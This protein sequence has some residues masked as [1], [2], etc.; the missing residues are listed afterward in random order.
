MKTI[1]VMIAGIAFC[2]FS[3]SASAQQTW[4]P[5]KNSTVDSINAKYADKILPPRPATTIEQIYPVIGQYQSSV[6]TDAASVSINLDEQS[7]G[8]IWVTGLPQGKIKAMLKKSP[9]TYRI[10]KQTL[11]DGTEVPEGTLMYDK[12]ANTL[13]ISIGNKYNEIDPAS[14]FVPQPVVVEEP[15]VK[16]KADKMKIK[17]KNKTVEP[18]V[19][20]Y[21]GTKIEKTTAASSTPSNQ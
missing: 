3:A 11:E 18:K 21:T 14:A 15:V 2:L 16:V 6:N 17:T 19:W 20:M 1:I 7:R 4:D 12:D 9:A 5:K 8:I 13:Q 10:P